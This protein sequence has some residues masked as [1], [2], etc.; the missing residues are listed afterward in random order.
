MGASLAVFA[1]AAAYGATGAFFSDSETSTGNTFTAGAI[2]L[3]VDSQQHYNGMLCANGTAIGAGYFWVPEGVATSTFDGAAAT[4]Y[5]LANPAQYPQAGTA[6]SGTW[7]LKD[8]QPTIDKFFNFADV[9]PGD[10]GENTV[11][12]HIDNNDAWACVDITNIANND[13]TNNTPEVLAGDVTPGPVGG[14]ELGANLNF[15]VWNDNGAG[16]GVAG[17]NIWNGTEPLL[18]SGAAPSVAQSYTLAAPPGAPLV[19]GSTGYIGVAWCAG[20]WSS[21]AQGATCNGATMGNIAQTDSYAADVAFRVEQSR[22]NPNFT[23]A[24]QVA[25]TTLTLAKTVLPALLHPDS[26]YTLA[27]NGPS[28]ISGIEGA[29]AVTAAGVVAGVYTLSESSAFPGAVVAWSCIGN[30]TPEVD[31]L[32]GTATVTIAPGENVGCE[33]TN[34][35]N[36]I[37]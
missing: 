25:P 9:K 24:P 19:G 1:G 20:T 29:P 28:V 14:G 32:D 26:A 30:A 31:N 5:N 36:N 3:K 17:D 13:N 6:C 11:S 21:I 10:N 2:D 23:C 15:I 7:T 4:A 37:D 33:V 22:N 27:A 35:Y 16:G 8:L 12:L 34:D 18:T